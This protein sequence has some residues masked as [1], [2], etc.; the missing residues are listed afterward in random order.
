MKHLLKNLIHYAEA[1]VLIN[2]HQFSMHIPKNVKTSN[3]F[4]KLAGTFA[5]LSDRHIHAMLVPAKTLIVRAKIEGG[6]A[7]C[8][9][10]TH[11]P[12]SADQIVC[13][14]DP[15]WVTCYQRDHP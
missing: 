7:R 5:V 14:N 8:S 13:H 3:I 2:I 12:V 9:K 15:Y 4:A 11:Q 6:D 1:V 10:I